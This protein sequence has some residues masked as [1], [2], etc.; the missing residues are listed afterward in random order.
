MMAKM[1]K[2]YGNLPSVVISP[3]IAVTHEILA[4]LD[5]VSYTM[6]TP[7]AVTIAGTLSN[8]YITPEIVPST[9]PAPTT[10]NA[11]GIN[12]IP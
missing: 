11:N 1:I 8:I 7:S 3:L 5:N 12:P 10:I 2:Q 9:M 6:Q 4:R